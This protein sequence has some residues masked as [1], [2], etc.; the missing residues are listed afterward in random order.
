MSGYGIFV[1]AWCSLIGAGLVFITGHSIWEAVHDSRQ[2][3]SQEL[4]ATGGTSPPPWDE[5]RLRPCG[6]LASPVVPVYLELTGEHVA[7][8]DPQCGKTFYMPGW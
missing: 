3:Y 5:R 7:N 6:E 1:V 8:W 2:A 4:T